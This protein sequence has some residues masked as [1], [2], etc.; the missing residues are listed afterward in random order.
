MVNLVFTGFTLAKISQSGLAH[1]IWPI[2]LSTYGLTLIGCNLTRL[3]K[4]IKKISRTHDN[5]ITVR[6]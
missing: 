3:K 4:E 5:S 6:W 1:F 2:A